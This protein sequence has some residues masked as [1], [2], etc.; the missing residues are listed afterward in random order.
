MQ[1]QIADYSKIQFS[2]FNARTEKHGPESVPAAD[3]T[4]LMDA[5]NTVLN[6]FGD[7]LLE[8]MY[9]PATEDEDD[10][11]EL[12]GVDPI[13]SLPKLKF[14]GL[15]PLKLDKKLAGYDLSIDYGL[16]EDSSINIFGCDVGKFTLELKEGGTVQLKFQV[17]CQKGLTE[18][19]MGK[20]AMLNG[21]EL[22][23][24]LLAPVVAQSTTDAG[25]NPFPVQDGAT[26]PLTAEDVFVNHSAAVH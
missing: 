6:Y 22:S 16:G 10:Q 17:Q 4:L 15:A 1:F 25:E 26:P 18:Q 13:S 19:I 20:L 12:D 2:N 7:G 5:P 14:P 3:L 23:V 21:Q 11:E 9:S 24:R 8:S